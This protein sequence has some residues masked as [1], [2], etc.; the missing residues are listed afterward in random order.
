MIGALEQSRSDVLAARQVVDV[1]PADQATVNHDAVPIP[2]ALCRIWPVEVVLDRDVVAR[3][4]LIDE[5]LWGAASTAARTNSRSSAVHL[6]HQSD[7]CV[8]WMMTRPFRTTTA[9]LVHAGAAAGVCDSGGGMMCFA[10]AVW[11]HRRCSLTQGAAVPVRKLRRIVAPLCCL[12]RLLCLLSG[13]RRLARSI[14]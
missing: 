9:T 13:R 12:C 7:A 4:W 14:V 5:R 2:G 10:T 1:V 6:A 3:R 8:R 11:R